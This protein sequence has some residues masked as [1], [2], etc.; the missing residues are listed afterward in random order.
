MQ[1]TYVIYTA[2]RRVTRGE[3]ED[4]PS[5]HAFLL[6]ADKTP[7][8]EISV[9]QQLHYN[10]SAARRLLPNV[11]KGLECPEKF[12]NI[13]AYPIVAGP[14]KDILEKWNYALSYA[15]YLGNKEI[16][17]SE[18]YRDGLSAVNCRSA[19]IATLKTIGIPY[20]KEQYAKTSG[21][22]CRSIPLGSVFSQAARGPKSLKE[23]WEANEIFCRVLP[24]PWISENRY[25]GPLK[26][27]F[28]PMSP[29]ACC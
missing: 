29:D 12:R 8:G 1:K 25:M 24:A 10:D 19:V 3:D 7:Q 16:V 23:L 9:L 15:F 27:G 18:D 26:H 2:E 22:E 11:R 14:P 28:L 6:L 13:K 5:S 17:L 21:T 20:C 4:D